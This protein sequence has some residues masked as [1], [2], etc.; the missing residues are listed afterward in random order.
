M[1]AALDTN[2]AISALIAYAGPLDDPRIGWVGMGPSRLDL[3]R[4]ERCGRES[5]DSTQIPHKEDCT[6]DRLLRALRSISEF[7]ALGEKDDR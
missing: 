4:C 5:A 2:E 6:A 1:I 3:F 7:L